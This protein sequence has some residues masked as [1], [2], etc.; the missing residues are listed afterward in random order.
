MK[1]LKHCFNI[2]SIIICFTLFNGFLYSN[3]QGELRSNKY[4]SVCTD[5]LPT[6]VTAYISDDEFSLLLELENGLTETVYS[7]STAILQL[8]EIS[9]DNKWAIVI[10]MPVEIDDGRVET[11]YQLI[12]LCNRKMVNDKI[13][14][15]IYDFV[16]GN[17]MYFMS[18]K[19]GLYLIYY[20]SHYDYYGIE[21]ISENE[22]KVP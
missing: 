12:D 2:L 1:T 4:L 20:S 13:K 19:S 16:P 9:P 11:T 10:S 3:Q 14:A 22:K 7:D 21:L 15:L 6:F 5:T 8:I 17:D 18:D